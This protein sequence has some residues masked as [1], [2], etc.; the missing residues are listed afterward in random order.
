MNKLHKCFNILFKYII[1]TFFKNYPNFKSKKNIINKLS[2]PYNFKNI[3]DVYM[4]SQSQSIQ[5]ALQQILNSILQEMRMQ[6]NQ[7]NEFVVSDVS[8]V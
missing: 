8:D 4:I 7:I 2:I 5:I 1:K 6:I 3:I